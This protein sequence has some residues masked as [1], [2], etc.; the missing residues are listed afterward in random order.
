MAS[1][2]K[3]DDIKSHPLFGE[4]RE[5][6][7]AFFYGMDEMQETLHP[8]VVND[9]WRMAELLDIDT[10]TVPTEGRELQRQCASEDGTN[11]E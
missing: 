9:I 3:Q 11:Q 6:L 8:W 2:W 4:L 7:I 1:E 5:H 10:K